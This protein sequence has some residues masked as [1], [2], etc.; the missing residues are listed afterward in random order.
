[1]KI[2]FIVLSLLFYS[3]TPIKS[4]PDDEKHKEELSLHE[5]QT[6]IDDMRH[7]L[8]CFQ[9]EFQIIDSKINSHEKLLKKVKN[10]LVRK[11]LSEIDNLA[12]KIKNIESDFIALEKKQRS[13][14]SDIKK[15]SMHAD[16]TNSFL[17]Q[18]K[19]KI[20]ELEKVIVSQNRR[21]EEIKELK[22]TLKAIASAIKSGE[23]GFYSY[24]VKAKDTLGEIARVH[25]ITIKELK[26]VNNLKK[27]TIFI[28]QELKIPK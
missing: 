12:A 9:T 6:N 5:V 26:R 25:G 17:S 21:F 20:R 15:I 24:R 27:D 16:K 10:E 18:Y 28:G 14:I 8:N 1:M 11:N 4:S 19:D 22:K 23:K 13:V 2:Y 7:D 3:C